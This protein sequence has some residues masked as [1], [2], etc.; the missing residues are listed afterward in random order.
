MN[1]LW[2][3][4]AGAG[5][6][7]FVRLIFARRLARARAEHRADIAGLRGILGGIVARIVA[8][9]GRYCVELVRLLGIDRLG[10]A[11]L[12]A[13]GQQAKAN[14][15]RGNQADPHFIPLRLEPSLNAPTAIWGAA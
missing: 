5:A 4:P 3:V 2:G 11:L 10:R 6:S 9:V 8:G 1:A 13:P 12:R 7:E 15:R 14:D